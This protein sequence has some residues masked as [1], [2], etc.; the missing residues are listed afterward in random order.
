MS[1]SEEVEADVDMGEPGQS[2]PER[3]TKAELRA[4]TRNLIDMAIQSGINPEEVEETLQDL[5]DGVQY[6]YEDAQRYI[7]QQQQQTPEE[8]QR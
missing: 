6:Y 1:E 2:E 7:I 3:I 8:S 5:C 4:E